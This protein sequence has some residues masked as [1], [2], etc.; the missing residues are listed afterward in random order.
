MT[1]HGGLQFSIQMPAASD[2]RSWTERVRSAEDLGFFSISVPDHLGPTLPQLAPLVALAHAAAITSRIRLA[3][4][5]LDN[6]FRH[7]VMLAKEIATLDLL[8]E[9]RVDL[10]MGAGWHEDDYTKTGV[11]TWDAAGTRVSRLWESI[12]VLDQLLTGDEVTFDGEFYRVDAFRSFPMPVQPR[13]PLMIGGGG[14]RMLTLAA[15]RAD[16]ISTIVMLRGGADKRREAF[17]EQLRWIADATPGRPP[18]LP[19]A[20]IGVRVFAGAVC[21]PGGETRRGGRPPAGRLPPDG[22]RRRDRFAVPDDRRPEPHPRPLR[23][24]QRTLRRHLLHA[25]RR[26]RPP[27]PRRDRGAVRMT[28]RSER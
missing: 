12:A 23:R 19:P 14:R 27:D 22:P 11:A 26:P 2:A 9:G 25:Q 20:R 3:M 13:I 17:E 7:P 28:G 16:I 10:G 18:E 1:V 24:D 5:V 15:G 21:T 4:T 8:S 6:D